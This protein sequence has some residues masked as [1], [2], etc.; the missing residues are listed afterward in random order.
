MPLKRLSKLEREKL[1]A[2][3]NEL[4]K[5]ISYLEELLA[6]PQKMLDVIKE[7]LLALKEKYGDARRTQI[8]DVQGV[9]LTT[10]ELLPEEDVLVLLTKKGPVLPAI[11]GRP[12]SR[13]A[14]PAGGRC[15]DRDGGGPGP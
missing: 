11:A 5:R 12:S 14:C 7:E 9:A 13:L 8:V 4:M 1:E 10:S 2:E 3:Y 15:A 6:S